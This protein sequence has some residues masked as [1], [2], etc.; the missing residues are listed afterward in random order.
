MKIGAR[1]TIWRRNG[2]INL[3]RARVRKQHLL[4]TRWSTYLKHGGFDRMHRDRTERCGTMIAV[5][6]FVEI[7][8]EKREVKHSETHKL[9][10]IRVRFPATVQLPVKIIRSCVLHQEQEN[11]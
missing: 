11:S 2:L 9:D 1:R 5:M 8:V 6:P 3:S 4:E 10:K 7:P